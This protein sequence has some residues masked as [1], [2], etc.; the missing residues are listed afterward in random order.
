MSLGPCRHLISALSCPP[1]S[2]RRSCRLA[3]RRFDPAGPVPSVLVDLGPAALGLFGPGLACLDLVGLVPFHSAAFD[4]VPVGPVPAAC[5]RSRRFDFGWLSGRGF[6]RRFSLCRSFASRL[7]RPLLAV[8]HRP[9]FWSRLS[10]DRRTPLGI[11]RRSPVS[12]IAS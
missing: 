12:R 10:F 6:V 8:G 2:T 3:P 4:S 1:A 5:L 9:P 11:V 7:G